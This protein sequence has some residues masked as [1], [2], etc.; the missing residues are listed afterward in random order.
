[1]GQKVQALCALF[2]RS[3]QRVKLD[4]LQLITTQQSAVIRLERD[5]DKDSTINRE[6]GGDSIASR[7]GT[8]DKGLNVLT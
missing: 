3:T 1:M 7:D 5:D 8:D 4:M 6:D 2:T